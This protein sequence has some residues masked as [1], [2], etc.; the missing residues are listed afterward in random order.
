MNVTKI[1]CLCFSEFFSFKIS[2]LFRFSNFQ[3]Q[4]ELFYW[5][6]P[7]LPLSTILKQH[8]YNVYIWFPAACIWNFSLFLFSVVQEDLELPLSWDK[9]LPPTKFCCKRR[10]V[11][12]TV[13]SFPRVEVTGAFWYISSR[14][15]PAIPIAKTLKCFHIVWQIGTVLTLLKA[16]TIPLDVPARPPR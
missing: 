2:R 8:S 6:F 12:A 16:P 5:P 15:E 7:V 1:K 3:A 9:G 4:S 14:A 13:M 11:Q 10:A